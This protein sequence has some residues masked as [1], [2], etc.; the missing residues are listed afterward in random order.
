MFEKKKTVA[1]EKAKKNQRHLLWMWQ[2]FAGAL[3]VGRIEKRTFA[4]FVKAIERFFII[5]SLEGKFFRASITWNIVATAQL[6]P[7][8]PWGVRVVYATRE[9]RW[10]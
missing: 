6:K 5:G 8:L 9:T 7:G 4:V 10:W 2:V 1:K 3:P